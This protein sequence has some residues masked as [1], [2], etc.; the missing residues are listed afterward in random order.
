MFIRKATVIPVI[1]CAAL[2][3]HP[4]RA[5]AQ[6]APAKTAPAA[7]KGAPGATPD[8][9][10]VLE[11]VRTAVGAELPARLRITAAGSGYRSGPDA[12]AGRQHYRIEHYVQELDLGAKTVSEEAVNTGD[13]NDAGQAASK[14]EKTAVKAG[15]PWPEQH[16]FWTTPFGFLTGASSYPLTLGSET[17]LG[18]PYRVLTFTVP[19]GQPVRGYLS[20]DNVLARARTDVGDTE[21]ESVFMDWKEFGD[22]KYPSLILQKTDGEVGR[23]LV[24][25]GLERY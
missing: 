9:A 8:A 4:V 12:S 17:L 22:I 11:S 1:A 23:I 21:V 10:S 2:A 25:Q 13:T 18:T 20:E 16:A 14:T 15:A 5:A 7:T 6:G 3:A 24:V 19:G